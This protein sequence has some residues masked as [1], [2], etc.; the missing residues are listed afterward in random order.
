M[1]MRNTFHNFSDNKL[2]IDK[3]EEDEISI[4]D[5]LNYFLGKEDK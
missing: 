4:E 5:N 1:K 2:K 3:N